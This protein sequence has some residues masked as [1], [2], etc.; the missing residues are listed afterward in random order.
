MEVHR[1]QLR[2]QE[3]EPVSRGTGRRGRDRSFGLCVAQG[4]HRSAIAVGTILGAVFSAAPADEQSAPVPDNQQGTPQATN[5]GGNAGTRHDV[6][7]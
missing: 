3:H 6:N 5:A 1:A 4:G 2:E 7:Q